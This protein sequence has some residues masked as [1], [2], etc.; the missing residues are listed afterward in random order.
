MILAG[1]DIGTNTFR[2]LVA[3][4]R[5]DAFRELH[6]ERRITRLGESLDRTGILSAA[7]VDRSIE[8]LSDFVVSIREH[9]AVAVS[10]VGTSAL[11]LASNSA[12]FLS[13]VQKKTGLAV[14]V[15][16]GRKEARLTLLGVSRA[17]RGAV[18]TPRSMVIDIGGGST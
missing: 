8:V 12:E 5:P 6:S 15:I 16:D 1:I 2:L 14:E 11:R 4:T 18:L 3:D 10:A 7:A 9:K 17:L 13:R